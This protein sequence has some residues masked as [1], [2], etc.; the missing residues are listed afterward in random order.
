MDLYDQLGTPA[1][2]IVL[3]ASA[4]FA[5]GAWS[6]TL[7]PNRITQANEFWVID[8]ASVQASDMRDS[9]GGLNGGFYL[10]QQGQPIGAVGVPFPDPVKMIRIPSSGDVSG[11]FFISGAAAP[12]DTAVSTLKP[13]IVPSNGW[14][15]RAQ[16]NAIAGVLTTGSNFVLNAIG[17]RYVCNGSV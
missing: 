3:T 17:R 14:N 12:W 8:S 5:S 6:V 11:I 10:A 7:Q 4:F 16:I 2:I 1:G 9:G 13:F 15:L